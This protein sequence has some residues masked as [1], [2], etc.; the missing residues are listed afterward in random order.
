MGMPTY[1]N[2]VSSLGTLQ[3]SISNRQCDLSNMDKS[4]G[5][6]IP[7]TI[8]TSNYAFTVGKYSITEVELGNF[9]KV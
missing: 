7:K 1:L 3:T 9:E 8:V 2:V 5:Q 4:Q 6:N